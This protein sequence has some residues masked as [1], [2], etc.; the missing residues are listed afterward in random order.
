MIFKNSLGRFKQKTLLTMYYYYKFKGH[1]SLNVIDKPSEVVYVPVRLIEY[2]VQDARLLPAKRTDKFLFKTIR[3]TGIIADGSW[4]FQKKRFID[5]LAYVAFKERFIERKEWEDTVYYHKFINGLKRKGEAKRDCKTWPEYKERHL[6]RWE[7][8]YDDIKRYGYKSQSELSGTQEKEIE[9]CVSR[10]GEI[11]FRDGR[12][13]LAIAKLLEVEEIP[14]V[15][16]IW[17]RDY[18]DGLKKT[19]NIR[20]TPREALRTIVGEKA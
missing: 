9:V 11:L 5:S 3:I 10:K 12:H 2:Q 14:V 6:K 16:N 17:H 7:R 4:D 15:V 18:I 19:A 1:K 13:R 20:I 8:L